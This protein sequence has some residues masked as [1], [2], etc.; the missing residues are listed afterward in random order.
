MF[1]SAQQQASQLRRLIDAIETK[2][3]FLTV[4]MERLPSYQ[5]TEPMHS[6]FRSESER[7]EMVHRIL[8]RIPEVS[9]SIVIP[10]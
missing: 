10:F 2:K 4:Y 7:L 1:S 9:S 5:V 6:Y 3:Y 8:I